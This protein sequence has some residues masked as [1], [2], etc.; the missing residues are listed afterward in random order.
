MTKQ[1]ILNARSLTLQEML[2]VGFTMEELYTMGEI[3]KEYYYPSDTYEYYDGDCF[4]NSNGNKLRDLREYDTH[5][6][7]Y[8]PF[9]DE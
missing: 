1:E 9:G 3:E 2:N 4:Y 5:S 8:T 6:E 7:G